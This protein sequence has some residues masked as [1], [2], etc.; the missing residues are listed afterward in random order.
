VLCTSNTYVYNID[1]RVTLIVCLLQSYAANTE[2]EDKNRMATSRCAELMVAAIANDLS[3]VW[4]C[5][6]PVLLLTYCM[7]FLPSLTFRSVLRDVLNYFV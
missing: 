5:H 1:E 7:Q 2:E 3:E 4:I 6:H